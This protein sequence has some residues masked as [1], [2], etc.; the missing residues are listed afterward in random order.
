[1]SRKN[2]FP[3]IFDWVIAALL[4]AALTLGIIAI[5]S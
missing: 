1:M 4:A 2:G 5:L 3:T